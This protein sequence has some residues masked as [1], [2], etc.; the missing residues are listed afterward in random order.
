MVKG[1]SDLANCLGPL[2][3]STS[4]FGEN[5]SLRHQRKGFDPGITSRQA[6]GDRWKCSWFA[7]QANVEF[8]SSEIRPSIWL[9]S[10]IVSNLRH[11]FQNS[12]LIWIIFQASWTT[13]SKKRNEKLLELILRLAEDG[14]DGVMAHKVLTLY[15]NL[16]A[17]LTTLFYV[18]CYVF[19]P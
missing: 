8:F 17:S 2:V 14:A 4:I 6:R 11:Y 19:R 13:A 18:G 9:Y 16:V 15:L 7:D 10:G 1:A 3:A 5:T 12:E